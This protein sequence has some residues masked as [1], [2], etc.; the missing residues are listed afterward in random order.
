MLRWLVGLA[1]TLFLACAVQAAP[2]AGREFQVLE[3]PRP[4]TTGP[5][6]E[7]IEF[8]YYGCPICYEAQ[9]HLARWLN[10]VANDVTLRRVPAI[11]SDGWEPFARSFYALETMGDLARL[12]WPIYDN[13]HF[14]GKD[15]KDQATMVE[16]V[17]RNG[18]DMQKF[19]QLWESEATTEKVHAAHKM[20]ELYNIRGVPSFVIDGKYVTSAR[21]AGST[22]QMMDVVD[23]LVSRARAERK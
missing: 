1:A 22:K 14:D 6:I 3:T 16:W 4:V 5:R 20:L 15:L 19:K 10:K 17:G 11:S 8:F 2:V 21:M 13:F 7:V 18:L 9:P 23:V 12:H